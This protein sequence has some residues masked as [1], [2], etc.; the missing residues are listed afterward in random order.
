MPA[1]E[2]GEIHATEVLASPEACWRAVRTTDFRE[3]WLI[4][5]LFRLRGLSADLGDLESFIAEGFDLVAEAPGRELVLGMAGGVRGRRLVQ[6]PT[7]PSG[8]A[9]FDAP[10]VIVIAW[11]FTVEPQGPAACRVRTET[12]VRATS[13]GARAAF[14]AYWFVV[15][16]FSALIRRRM[17]AL[18]RRAATRPA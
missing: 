17:L 7:P 16:P 15:G 12:R 4:R 3:S 2:V 9:A 11:N 5:T 8:L 10:G 1:W 6:F 13:P 18:I 14:R